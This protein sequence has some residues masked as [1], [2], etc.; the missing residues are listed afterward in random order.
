MQLIDYLVKELRASASYNPA[1]Q[2][3]P[4]AVI[5]TDET[6]QWQGA[7]PYIKECLPELLEFGT[8]NREQRTG[9]AIWL[10]CVLAGVLDDVTLPADKT[11]IIYLP[12]VG[13]K[14]MRA[15]ESCSDAL[16]PL[17]ELQ[18]RGSWF[19]Y[20]SGR[21]WTLNAFL[22]YPGV[23]L[24]LDVAQD[25]KTQAVL[26]QVL[27]DLLESPVEKLQGQRLEAKDFQAL[28]FNDPIKD[29]LAWMN[30]PQSKRAQWDDSKWQVFCNACVDLLGN[31]PNE[32]SMP[33]LLQAL[34]SA[35]GPWHDAWQRFE[36]TAHNLPALVRAL[37]T[38]E[39]MDLAADHSHYP[40]E[41]SL[42]EERIEKTLNSFH[43]EGHQ[44]CAISY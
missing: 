1:V 33:E 42:E 26:P 39:P 19:A 9:P 11:P 7:M 43:G 24:E 21:D 38:I 34:A 29:L 8:Y 12:G 23:G 13:R 36:D 28:V 14:A 27:R 10:K 17:A 18:Y 20:P 22:T 3:A 35:K 31:V 44:N 40:S 4:A 16:R 30:D 37:Q 15:I 41:N 5:W 6:C 2:I 32:D 25:K